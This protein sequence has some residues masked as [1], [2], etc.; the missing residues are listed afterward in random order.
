MTTR[1]LKPISFVLI[2]LVITTSCKGN[3][4]SESPI[5][6]FKSSYGLEEYTEIYNSIWKT[7]NL[8]PEKQTIETSFGTARVNLFKNGSKPNLVLLPGFGESSNSFATL[9]DNL[10]DDFSLYLPDT[11]GDSGFSKAL[12]I[13]KKPEQMALWLDEIITELNIE[14][15]FILGGLSFGGW[16]TMNYAIHYPDKAKKLILIAPAE[17]VGK[18]KTKFRIKGM[19]MHFFP[20]EKRTID[21]YRYTTRSGKIDDEYKMWQDLYIKQA[22][23]TDKNINTFHYVPPQLFSKEEISNIKTPI[24]LL[25]GEEEIIYDNLEKTI[26]FA[27]STG[28]EVEVIP[29]ANHD[30]LQAKLL[31]ICN[32]IKSFIN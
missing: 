11:I 10:K 4:K 31:E 30:I 23:S 9:I 2:I 19:M 24:L 5:Y 7:F 20:S 8:S 32:S 15:N 25:L 6:P 18:M 3:I 21:M 26:S 12:N 16:Q 28:I 17:T 29:G 14:N 27:E 22:I 1:L 13:P